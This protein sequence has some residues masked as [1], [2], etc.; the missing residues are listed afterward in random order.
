M[1]TRD[2][3]S[4]RVILQYSLFSL[5]FATYF[6]SDYFIT[7]GFLASTQTNYDV[8]LCLANNLNTVKQLKVV[9]LESMIDNGG[10]D[11]RQLLS[12]SVVALG[13]SMY[14]SQRQLNDYKSQNF[15]PAFTAFFFTRDLYNADNL[16]AYIGSYSTASEWYPSDSFT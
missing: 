2:H 16:C 6:I 10:F 11:G 7:R 5:V 4:I 13:S 15:H 3:T 12:D 1:Q 9:T 14:L 8:A